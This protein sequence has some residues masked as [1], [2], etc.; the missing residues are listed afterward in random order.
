MAIDSWA[1]LDVA[2]INKH[3]RKLSE[4]VFR[5][6]VLLQLLRQKGRIT[7]NHAGKKFDWRVRFRQM[8]P[9]AYDDMDVTSFPRTNPWKSCELPY[10]AYQLG[11]SISKFE[12]L[13][14]GSTTEG[15]IKIVSEII[16]LLT[17]SMTDFFCD[18]IYKDGN[19]TSYTSIH[20]LESCFG[21]SG[22]SGV[23]HAASDTYAGLSTVL[24]TYG[25]SWA[26][27]WPA[28][29]GNLE[30]CFFTPLTVD[31]DNAG[32]TGS[33]DTWAACCREQINY[34]LAYMQK[35]QAESPD[36]IIMDTEYYRLFKETLVAKE[37]LQIT[38]AA[39]TIGLGTKAINYEGIPCVTEYG[40]PANTMYALVTDKME[41]RSMQGQL[42]QM[43]TAEEI[44]NKTSKLS[45]DF[46]G[47]MSIESP[48]FAGK[49]NNS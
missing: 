11:E 18:E 29:T 20:G 35:L 33:T 8:T 23:L 25:G 34:L 10:R 14:N 44:D 48:A 40:V 3:I 13:A 27:T 37:Q 16:K 31:A 26:G 28:G 39:P 38:G 30:Y 49:I 15:L 24:G 43:D 41:I 22:T 9:A 47:N 36:L 7:Y 5:K 19:S 6:R 4:P 42:F 46:F 12:K 21:T 17:T 1:R 45:L 32:W 2:T